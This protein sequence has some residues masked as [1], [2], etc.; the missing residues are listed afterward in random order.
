MIGVISIAVRSLWGCFCAPMGAAPFRKSLRSIMHPKISNSPTSSQ[1]REL[2]LMS[3]DN[4]PRYDLRSR[5][6]ATKC[7]KFNPFGSDGAS[8]IVEKAP[9]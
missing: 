9:P 3:K 6:K 8:A 4:V 1:S 2:A 7:N 5:L